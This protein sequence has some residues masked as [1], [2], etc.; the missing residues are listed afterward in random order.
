MVLVRPGVVISRQSRA[1]PSFLERLATPIVELEQAD[2]DVLIEALGESVVEGWALKETADKIS[3]AR[4][5]D[6][7]ARTTEILQPDW[8]ET[9]NTSS[10]FILN[11]PVIPTEGEEV[12]IL[13][14]AETDNTD[15]IPYSKIGSDIARDAEIEDWAKTAN[16]STLVPEDKI[17]ADLAR[18]SEIQ[19]WAKTSD[20][21]V[22]PAAKIHADIARDSEI[23]SWAKA[24]NISVLPLSKIG[25][26]IAR[27][28]DVPI[29]VPTSGVGGTANAITL[30]PSPVITAYEVGMEFR[31]FA[32]LDNTG[33]VTVNVSGLG[34]GV[35][36]KS[37]G[38]GNAIVLNS[39]DITGNDPVTI[40]LRNATTFDI[41]GGR[42]GGAA[43]KNAGT[44]SGQVPILS[45][46]GL[47]AIARIPNLNASKITAGLLAIARIP[48]LN[49]SKITAGNLAAARLPT[50]YTAPNSTKWGNYSISTA[51]TGSTTN[52]I[53]FRT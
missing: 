24:G 34:A 48:N 14:W 22:I 11:K 47:F 37:G 32:K 5:P 26:K 16:S 35:V 52:T 30:T 43:F 15:T 4:I 45:T 19:S 25:N 12:S 40:R 44:L 27:V 33:S 7:I 6:T 9:A 2:V 42:L 29:F 46:G 50:S 39:G 53:Y 21:T 10:A 20:T 3:E 17:H 41:V 38:T 51:A 49:A 36:Y 8:N 13:S 1:T 31:F 23:Q 28:E 18:D